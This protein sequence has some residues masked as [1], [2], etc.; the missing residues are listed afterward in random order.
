MKTFFRILI[1]TLFSMNLNAQE[2]IILHTN[3][4]HSKLTGYG[5]ESEYSP[6]ITGND[7]TIG[8]FARLATIFEET[9]K[10]SNA[11]T[12][13]LDAGDFLMG[14]L[15][16]F[17]ERET[18]FQ[19]N[20]M[21]EIGYDVITLGNHEF[22]F[23]PDALAEILKSAKKN[24]E[25]PQIVASNMKFS[26]KSTEDDKLE[27]FYKDS[28]IQA[29]TLIEKNGLKI[30]LFG[31]VGEDAKDVAP[32]SKPVEF[33]NPIKTAAKMAKFLKEEKNVDIIICLSHG[34]VYFNEQEKVFYGEDMELAEKVPLID[35]IISGHTHVET[36]K[37]IKVNNTYIVQTGSYAQNVGKINLKFENNKISSLN[38]ELLSVDD[39]IKGNQLVFDKIEKQ[40]EFIDANYLSKLGLTYNQQIAETSFDLVCKYN[41]FGNSNLGPFVAD[42]ALYYAN[43]M[44]SSADFSLVTSGTIRE[45]LLKGDKGIIGVPDIFR[46]MSLGQGNDGIPGY[47]LAQI[48]L[49]ANEVK[50]LMEVLVIS[51]ESGGDGYLFFSGIK[52][53]VDM[54][55]GML[56]KIQKIEIKGK[57][58]DYSKKNSQLFSLTANTYLLSFIG[59]I[60][61]MSHGLVNV[62]P[63][64]K[65]GNPILDIKNMLI[66][67]NSELEGVQE[68]KEWIAI[69]EYTKTFEKNSNSLPII[70]EKYK[71]GDR[72]VEKLKNK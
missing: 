13:I 45:D 40:K 50:K 30:G 46:V 48:Y 32:A 65:S 34:G 60:K 24:G 38:F 23:G 27:G 19:L 26:E 39:N 59:R 21:K 9:R 36:P 69:I 71:D 6:L 42:A 57:E 7:S 37:P 15:F 2:L 49:T 11:N 70:P 56:K 35:I 41:D 14:S 54:D 61:K 47:P 25:I 17:A 58:I 4:L 63:K 29:Y 20:L 64:D 5:P 1:F 55:K 66:D 22:D 72:S 18:G 44:G 67:V 28:T 51:R 43:S 10:Q 12:L 52:L 16:H 53:Y 31:L 62:I 3:D 33:L 8:G 68:A